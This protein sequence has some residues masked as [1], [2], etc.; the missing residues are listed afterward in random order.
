MMSRHVAQAQPE[1]GAPQGMTTKDRLTRV[2]EEELV[3]IVEAVPAHRGVL[4]A[5][6]LS[7]SPSQAGGIALEVRDQLF[8]LQ[9]LNSSLPSVQ[10]NTP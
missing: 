8:L 2:R 9:T 10:E 1:L 4:L 5:R 7:C 6:I 3:S